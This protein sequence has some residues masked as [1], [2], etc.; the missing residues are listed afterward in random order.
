LKD[1]RDAPC[2]GGSAFDGAE[3]VVDPVDQH[4]AEVESGELSADPNSAGGLGRELGHH[5]RN[6]GIDEALEKWC[7]Y[8]RLGGGQVED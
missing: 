2:I 7:Q 4:D 3:T 5:D 6:G 1:D 8:R